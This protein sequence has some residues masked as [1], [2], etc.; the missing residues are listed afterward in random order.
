MPTLEGATQNLKGQLLPL[1]F[2]PK[3]S[4]QAVKET[5]SKSLNGKTLSVLLS[6]V[7][8]SVEKFRLKT[9]QQSNLKE[10]KTLAFYNIVNGTVIDL[11]P[12]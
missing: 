9:L 3:T 4:I 1:Q 5:L 12:R 8:F 2:N 11:I 7:G 6:S 10:D